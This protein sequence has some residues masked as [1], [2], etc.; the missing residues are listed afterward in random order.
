MKEGTGAAH[1]DRLPLALTHTRVA[2]GLRTIRALSFK[3]RFRHDPDSLN[4]R[5]GVILFDQCNELF[6]A[7]GIII[8]N[9][10]IDR[11]L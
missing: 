3:S 7:I 9:F 4:H 5:L 2:S 8:R 10:Q 6:I 1:P 11:A